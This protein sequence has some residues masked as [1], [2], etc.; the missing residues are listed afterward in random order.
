M[1]AINIGPFQKIVDLRMGGVVL[2]INASYGADASGTTGVFIVRINGHEV[3]NQTSTGA[4][5]SGFFRE[6]IKP[7]LAEQDIE[8]GEDGI[9]AVNVTVNATWPGDFPGNDASIEAETRL[10]GEN[11]DFR[12]T[13]VD[14]PTGGVSLNL[15]FNLNINSGDMT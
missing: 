9:V 1:M 4:I 11:V 14:D 13:H 15:S 6:T 2:E 12:E 5:G 7:F 3:A 10:R 8:V